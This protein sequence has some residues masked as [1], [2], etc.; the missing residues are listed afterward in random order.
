MFH[1]ILEV[2]MSA[3]LDLMIAK[4]VST[5]YANKVP[6]IGVTVS[7]TLPDGLMLKPNDSPNG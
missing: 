6:I 2:G 3:S 5:G 1:K 4:E 7:F